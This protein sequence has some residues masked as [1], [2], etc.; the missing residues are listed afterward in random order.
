MT[1]F[2]MSIKVHPVGELLATQSALW[3]ETLWSD[4]TNPVEISVSAAGSHQSELVYSSAE[5]KIV[6]DGAPRTIKISS[7]SISKS[8]SQQ[9]PITTI[10]I[11][12]N[13]IDQNNIDQNNS[14]VYSVDSIPVTTVEWEQSP[15]EWVLVSLSSSALVWFASAQEFVDDVVRRTVNRELYIGDYAGRD[16]DQIYS[17]VCADQ[18]LCAK[19]LFQWSMSQE[20]KLVYTALF[21]HLVQRLDTHMQTN[22]SMSN[23]IQQ[24]LVNK[25]SDTVTYC[26]KEVRWCSSHTIVELNLSDMS[27]VSEWFE[28][29][30]HELW[31]IVDL[32][33]LRGNSSTIDSQYTEFGASRFS[34]DD[35]SIAFYRICRSSETTR[36]SDCNDRS[37]AGWYAMTNPFEDRAEV[38]NLYLNHRSMLIAMSET[39]SQLKQKFRI[40]DRLFGGQSI[41]DIPVWYWSETARSWDTTRL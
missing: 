6:Q 15:R 10:N 16:L 31:H 39:S 40:M 23:T 19:I 12:Q 41:A 17:L 3:S 20:E 2:G 28:V 9:S 24:F 21:V 35:P 26:S 30:T 13:N 18:P 33:V 38:F 1:I 34:I 7:M 5:Q 32:G 25:T 27:S 4:T 11:D 8:T 14:N 36:K 29:L 37:F 22:R